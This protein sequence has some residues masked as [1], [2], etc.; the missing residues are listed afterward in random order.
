MCIHNFERVDWK[1]RW[2]NI[3][4]SRTDSL[5]QLVLVFSVPWTV[6]P[7]QNYPLLGGEVSLEAEFMNI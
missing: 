6:R 2:G 1:F 5:G 3:N 7:R 4:Q